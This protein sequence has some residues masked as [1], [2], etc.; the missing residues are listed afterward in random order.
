MKS[1]SVSEKTEPQEK[2]DE[3]EKSVEEIIP[4]STANETLTSKSVPIL[5]EALNEA[6]NQTAVS[7]NKN[8]ESVSQ[9]TP[10]EQDSDSLS[11]PGRI[12]SERQST[13]A[14]DE[15]TSTSTEQKNVK[16]D[17]T[18]TEIESLP[19][20]ANGKYE[21][22]FETEDATES[23]VESSILEMSLNESNLNFSYSTVGMVRSLFDIFSMK[24]FWK[25][26]FVN[27]Y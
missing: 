9:E 17:R 7:L 8:L 1:H 15:A 21:S 6:T 23:A 19:N 13:S 22:E 3:S 11:P 10:L 5:R 4:E 16:N 25:F 27:F 12:R 14:G 18:D 24:I 20:D 2:S 26:F